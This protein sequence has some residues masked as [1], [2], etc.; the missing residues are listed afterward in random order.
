MPHHQ[1]L[2]HSLDQTQTLHLEQELIHRELYTRRHPAQGNLTLEGAQHGVTT[3][4]T[5]A[6]SVSGL[7]TEGNGG[8]EMGSAVV[9]FSGADTLFFRMQ[10]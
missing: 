10:L 1:V 4:T 3:V 2:P 8:T 9:G 7:G 5:M 6:C